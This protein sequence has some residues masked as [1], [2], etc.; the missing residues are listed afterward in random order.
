MGTGIVVIGLACLIIGETLVGRGGIGRGV[1]AVMAG[2]VVYRF[3]Y[4]AV[5]NT[6]IVPIEC[7]KLVTALVVA[8]AIAAPTIKSGAA[9]QRRRLAAGRKGGR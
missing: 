3:I 5:L 9:F 7:L 8:A 1:L 4:A 2:S 6:R